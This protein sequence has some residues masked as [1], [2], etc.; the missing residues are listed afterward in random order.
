MSDLLGYGL[1]QLRAER[2]EAQKLIADECGVT[3][4]TVSRWE[5]SGVLP[6]EHIDCA[7]RA[8][9]VDSRALRQ[10]I[11]RGLAGQV[12]RSG[13]LLNAWREAIIVSGY[14]P[15][16]A[17]VLLGFSL[18]Q[19]IDRESWFAEVQSSDVAD[20]L[21][22]DPDEVFATWDEVTNSPFIEAIGNSGRLFRLRFP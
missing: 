21:H 4:T 13:E 8:L 11:T 14:A 20:A 15:T 3:Q 5:K 7:C 16:A 1:R 19:F 17:R 22:L 6:D 18:P 2:G 10:A 12:V 9:E